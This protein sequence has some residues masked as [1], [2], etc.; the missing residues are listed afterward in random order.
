MASLLLFSV[1]S[2]SDPP[3]FWS[4]LKIIPEKLTVVFSLK[5]SMQ[6]LWI[7]IADQNKSFT[8]VE[9]GKGTENERMPFPRKDLANVNRTSIRHISLLS[10]S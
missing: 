9:R 4:L 8:G 5:L 7:V 6:R 3:Y 2:D 1:A 10:D